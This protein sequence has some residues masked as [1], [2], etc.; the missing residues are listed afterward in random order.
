VDLRPAQA[1]DREPDALGAH[2]SV[3]LLEGRP[4][5][6][7]GL[8]EVGG[9]GLELRLAQVGAKRRHQLG[10]ARGEHVE[11]PL[12]LVLPPVQGPGMAALEAGPQALDHRRDGSDGR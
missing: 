3:G 7:G 10:P 12:Q 1:R 9:P 5:L 8:A 4:G 2:P 11:E 6:A